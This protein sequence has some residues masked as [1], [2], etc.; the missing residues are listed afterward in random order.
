MA[1]AMKLH[2]DLLL[3]SGR[4]GSQMRLHSF[5]RHA[6]HH[7]V[8]DQATQLRRCWLHPAQIPAL[9]FN[10]ETKNH[11]R[12]EA[13]AGRPDGGASCCKSPAKSKDIAAHHCPM[14]QD[15]VE[16]VSFGGR[17]C[18][19]VSLRNRNLWLQWLLPPQIAAPG[20][21]RG[22]LCAQKSAC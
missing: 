1:T 11:C 19:L 13:A 21:K 3:L 5:R 18:K 16:D 6:R 10:Q 12:P 4:K 14:S 17:T 15:V 22:K 8:A 9:Q 2:M 20:A 7:P